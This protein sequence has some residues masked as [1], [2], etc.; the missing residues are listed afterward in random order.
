MAKP[1]SLKTEPRGPIVKK[2]RM[3][4][5]ELQTVSLAEGHNEWVD[6]I[7]A[8]QALLRQEQAEVGMIQS[9]AYL[10]L[11]HFGNQINQ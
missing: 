4:P 8:R 9:N 7:Y 3:L 11:Q 6:N 1:A 2:P 5:Q 10:M